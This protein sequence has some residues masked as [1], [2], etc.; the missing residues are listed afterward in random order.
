M[1]E[2]VRDFGKTGK[3][4]E[5]NLYTIR[6]G[7]YTA[8]VSDYGATLVSFVIGDKDG[9][10]T[11]VV[12]GYD[13]VAGYE[14]HD[15]C[16]GATVGRNA[17]RIAKAA[18]TLHGVTYQL[19]K[20]DGENNLHSGPDTYYYRMWKT[21]GISPDGASV[22][23]RLDTPDG[24]QGYPGA[25]S[26]T[27]T[28]TLDAS[29]RLSISYDAESDQDT[30]CNMTNHSYFNLNGDGNGDILDHNLKIFSDRIT[31]I[32]AGTIPTGKY[33]PV[34]GTPFDF[35]NGKSVGADINADDEQLRFGNGYDHNF[36]FAMDK[37]PVRKLAEVISSVT[38]LRLDVYSDLP[39]MQLY[40]GNY[41]QKHT[42]KSGHVYDR[43]CGFALET[44]YF[45]NS[46]NIADFTSP[47]LPAGE[48]Y[49]SVTTYQL[50]DTNA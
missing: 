26:V 48:K 34:E 10:K 14:K 44:Q 11:D 5:A 7:R 36:V 46:I 22:S 6:A 4:E 39:G 47:V 30:I 42:G 45:P 37:G 12:L 41:L 33:I 15:Y 1:S 50:I 27:V 35:R 49:H 29:G 2:S 19:A 40:T 25:F 23:F 31:E 32:D 13:D 38:G 16:F 21:D 20:N 3:G 18:F 9:G 8:S 24:D 43:R 17:N 28:Y